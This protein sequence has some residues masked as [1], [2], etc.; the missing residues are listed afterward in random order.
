MPLFD[1]VLVQ[2]LQAESVSKGGIM[3]PEKS[4][5]KVLE[6]TVLAHGPGFKNDVSL[7]S[8]SNFFN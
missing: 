2:R 3:L 5:G 6:A 1:R 7:F 4:K 8:L